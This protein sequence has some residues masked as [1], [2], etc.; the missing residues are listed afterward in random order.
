[1]PARLRICLPIAFGVVLGAFAAGSCS[2]R[3]AS[4]TPAPT[5][6]QSAEAQQEFQPI[7]HRWM[8]A[9]ARERAALEPALQEFRAHYPTEPLVRLANVMLAIIALDR[10]DTETAEALAAQVRS[11]P[12]GSTQDVASLVVGAAL[13]RRGKPEA[14]LDVLAPLV[15][16]LIDPYAQSMLHEQIV[17]ASVQ[18][19]RWFEALAYMDDWLR[20]AEP[21]ELGAVRDTVNARLTAFP[22]DTLELALRA[23]KSKS[24]A[25]YGPDIRQAVAS[26]LSEV[27]ISKSDPRLARAVL[28]NQGSMEALGDAGDTL[29][30]L[31]TSGG[32][33]PRVVGHTVGM[34]L[35]SGDAALRSRA[36]QAIAGVLEVFGPTQSTVESDAGSGIAPAQSAGF[37]TRDHH[38]I[39]AQWREPFDELAHEGASVIV[40]GFDAEGAQ[41]ASRYAESE[42][43]PVI[44]LTHPASLD[45]GARFT[46]VLGESD[47]GLAGG[48][49][50]AANKTGKRSARVGG[51]EASPSS[52]ERSAPCDA[53]AGRAGDLRFPLSRWRT[54][55]VGVLGMAG[56]E[57]CARDLFFELG[58]AKYAPSIVI[59]PE[60]LGV[61]T[62]KRYSGTVLRA[63]VGL[64]GST[65]HDPQ[66]QLWIRAHGDTPHWYEA[67]GRDAAILARAAVDSLPA[68]NTSNLRDV[69]SR[70]ATAQRALESASATLWTTS[71]NGFAGARRMK[72]QI[73]Y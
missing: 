66:V 21:H 22:T 10:G 7:R 1:M 40:A 64:L 28:E 45:A 18:A 61:E 13:C 69:A 19:H 60:A 2:G 31:A 26:R 16:K 3:Q 41:I 73:R 47:E 12:A 67:L 23:M 27:A 70:R 68:D 25:G 9:S 44:L 35:P 8:L 51:P 20:S 49:M 30:Q 24:H 14:A 52:N 5:L 62:P 55:Q 32:A 57:V 53:K 33:A 38:D 43:I 29:A 72:R 65:E 58:E 71:E 39:A 50:E 56:P 48:V 46:F 6:A 17:D 54:E 15:G 36:A 63:R 34:V 59:G 37:L 11:G 42:S 4:Q